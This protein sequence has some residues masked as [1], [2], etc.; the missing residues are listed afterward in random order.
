M[1]MSALFTCMPASQKRAP[2]PVIDGCEPLYGLLEIELRTSA[3][4][5]YVLLKFQVQIKVEVIYQSTDVYF[6]LC[7]YVCM[8]GEAV[9]L[10]G[11]S[12]RW[13]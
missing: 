1:C 12:H 8:S 11:W 3:Y 9:Y 7:M 13:L 6:K 4:V 5:L 10:L 2:N